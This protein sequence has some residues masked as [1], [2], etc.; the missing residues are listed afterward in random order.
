MTAIGSCRT[1]VGD[2]TWNDGDHRNLFG[3]KDAVSIAVK[4]CVIICAADIRGAKLCYFYRQD[5]NMVLLTYYTT[6]EPLHECI[7]TISYTTTISPAMH[8]VRFGVC[9]SFCSLRKVIQVVSSAKVTKSATQNA[10]RPVNASAF[11]PGL[12]SVLRL[13]SG[14]EGSQS[15]D[16]QSPDSQ[17]RL[18]V[19]FFFSRL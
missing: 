17:S 16:Y 18:P 13:G 1:M 12:S 11:A 4:G 8:P 19:T 5:R 15:P 6:T 10:V 7:T 2:R 9:L 3:Q 14:V